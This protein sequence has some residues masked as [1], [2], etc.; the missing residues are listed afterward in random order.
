M[1]SKNYIKRLSKYKN[2]LYRLRALGLVK[3]F[4]DNLADAVG[5]KSSQVRKDFSL[6]GI[7]GSKK[8]GYQVNEL[9]EQL[10]GILGKKEQYRVVLVG[11]GNIGN[12]LINYNG[13][14]GEGIKIVAG[15]DIE[16]EKYSIN[17]SLPIMHVKTLSEYVVNNNIK[18]AIIAVPDTAA[19][20]V[21]DSLIL[22]GIKGVLNFAPIRLKAPDSV[23]INNVNIVL[24]IESVIYYVNNLAIAEKL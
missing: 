4:S 11:I 21:L 2:A 14:E 12:A 9:I 24:E 23:V 8:G 17:D 22:S 5:V 16:P 20:Q 10:N 19:Q 6:F 15:F 18:I 7:K 1:I 13:F 3:I